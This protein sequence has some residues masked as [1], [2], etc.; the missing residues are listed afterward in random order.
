LAKHLIH[1]LP[2]PT[3]SP[4][5]LPPDLIYTLNSKIAHKGKEDFEQW[6]TSNVTNDWKAIPQT[7]SSNASKS[8]NDASFYNMTVLLGIIF[9]KL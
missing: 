5:L 6:K 9:S 7:S 4:D 3:S 2:Q 1:T 8:E